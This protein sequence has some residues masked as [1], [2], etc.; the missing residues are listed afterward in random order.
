MQQN[1]FWNRALLVSVFFHL[2]FLPCLGIVLN[3]HFAAQ[4]PEKRIEL[5]LI[6]TAAAQALG[7]SNLSEPQNEVAPPP[8]MATPLTPPVPTETKIREKHRP[9][10]I[11]PNE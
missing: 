11:T 1:T 6:K 3:S 7:S 8:K 10:P 2:M 9:V 4:P 5:E